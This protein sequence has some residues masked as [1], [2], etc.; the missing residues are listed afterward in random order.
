MMAQSSLKDFKT[1]HMVQS[2]STDTMYPV[3]EEN[4]VFTCKCKHFKFHE[5]KTPCRHIL[6]LLYNR[7]IKRNRYLETRGER[8]KHSFFENFEEVLVHL[9]LSNSAEA[10]YLASLILMLA[11]SQG[12]VV[13]DDIYSIIDGK[14]AKTG[15]IMGSTFG[16]LQKKGLIMHKPLTV[17]C[18]CGKHI[19]VPGYHHRV[20]SRTE[21][22][23]GALISTWVLTRKGEDVLGGL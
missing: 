15:N 4:G 2:A 17:T 18:D 1:V 10:E 16:L 13:S 7:A 9:E 6:E 5:H 19:R 20:P 12:E 22:N 11:K 21:S 14:F 3:T 8:R 23:H